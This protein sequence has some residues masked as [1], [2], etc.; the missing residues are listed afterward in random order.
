MIIMSAAR[1]YGSDGTDVLVFHAWRSPLGCNTLIV[2]EDLK[3]GRRSGAR[4]V[5]S[6]DGHMAISV[7]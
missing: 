5:R 3:G 2:V 6:G 7:G 4:I 1:L